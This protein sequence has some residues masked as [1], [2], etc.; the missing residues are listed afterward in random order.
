[1]KNTGLVVLLTAMYFLS[2]FNKIKNF[3]N[4][5]DGFNNKI[6]I[7]KLAYIA[8]IIAI[9][10]ELIA[11]IIM[12]YS[13]INHKFNNY[14]RYATFSL[15]LFTILATLIYHFPPYANNYYPFMSNLTAI[16]GL[17]IFSRCLNRF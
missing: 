4:V 5:V 7:G 8:I 3:Q 6:N 1:M 11:P 12:V 13:T 17:M 16:A 14:A 10:I 2:G 15:V 9:L